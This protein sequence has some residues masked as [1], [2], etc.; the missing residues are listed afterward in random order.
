[1]KKVVIKILQWILAIALLGGLCAS[2]LMMKGQARYSV[3][4]SQ[5]H[6]N[7]HHPNK[8]EELLPEEVIIKQL[9]FDIAD[10]NLQPINTEEVE[11]ALKTNIP[12]IKSVNA[13]ISPE[14][15]QLNIDITGRKPIL[16]FFNSDKSYFLDE[17]G[18]YLPTSGGVAV[19]LPIVRLSQ[20]SEEVRHDVLLPLAQY[21]QEHDEWYS[22][23]GMIEIL[24]P[25]KVHFYPRVGDVIFETI[26]VQN[27]DKDLDK[28]KIFYKDIVPQVGANKYALVK[29]SFDNQIVCKAR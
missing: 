15:H 14:E 11:T 28:I 21:L 10:N 1:M 3:V 9:P 20:D 6:I 8:T 18:D 26:G 19:Y 24:S 25:T 23:F 17:D 16:R 7:V 27:L 13:Y 5:T 12:F 2:Y 29:L 4:P 22:F